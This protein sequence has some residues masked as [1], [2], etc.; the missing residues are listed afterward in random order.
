MIA[1]VVALVAAV[2]TFGWHAFQRAQD[3]ADA[4]EA[5]KAAEQEQARVAKF[6]SEAPR[7]L[8]RLAAPTGFHAIADDP[9]CRN[10]PLARCFS[11]PQRPDQAAGAV[12][13]MLRLNG[14]LAYKALDC[15]PPGSAT[16]RKVYG[17]WMPCFGIGRI[18]GIP[19]SV[20]VSPTRHKGADG[21]LTFNG[22]V[23][24]VTAES[25]GYLG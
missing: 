19:V 18:D 21:R 13:A 24:Q 17:V 20:L 14:Y 2:G 10:G 23:L 7:A 4:K 3:R 15:S 9:D 5:S 25:T 11:A 22:S 12:S 16:A 1:L 8:S 6:T